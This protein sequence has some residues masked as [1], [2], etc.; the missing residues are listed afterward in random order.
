MAVIIQG[1]NEI[2]SVFR[3][4]VTEDNRLKV[5]SFQSGTI[6]ISG[7]IIIGSVTANVDSIYIQSGNNMTGSFYDI[8]VTP[9][10]V[11]ANPLG[12]LTY[13]ANDYVGSITAVIGANSYV[14]RLIYSGISATN[15]VLVNIGSW[16]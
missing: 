4:A 11:S 1:E 10:L 12:S 3:A 13:I 7:N 2:G 6:T 8:P 15:Q 9:T 16:S 14:K 5:E